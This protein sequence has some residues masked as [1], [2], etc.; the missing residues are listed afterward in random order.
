MYL[1]VIS[2][3]PCQIY[4]DTLEMLTINLIWYKKLDSTILAI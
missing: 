4:L 3:F 1:I 2:R